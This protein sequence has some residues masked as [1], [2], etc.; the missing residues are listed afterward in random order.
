MR[1]KL[2]RYITILSM[3]VT[4]YWHVVTE[5]PWTLIRNL[6]GLAVRFALAFPTCLW[7]YAFMAGLRLCDVTLSPP[8]PIERLL[9]CPI[10]SLIWSLV[11]Y[12]YIYDEHGVLL[13]HILPTVV[14]A[15][16]I[17]IVWKVT[18]QH[19]CRIASVKS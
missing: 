15:S 18:C 19:R 11:M 16:V 1:S 12:Q 2:M 7:L 3:T 9:T 14:V 13:P 6:L 4:A 8:S 17:A 5:R 10:G